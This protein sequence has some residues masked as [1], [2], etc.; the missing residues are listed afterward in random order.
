MPIPGAG[1]WA[2]VDD[3]G[4]VD[5]FPIGEFVLE[6]SAEGIATIR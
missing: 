4:P 3:P 2:S 5:A 1:V 6:E